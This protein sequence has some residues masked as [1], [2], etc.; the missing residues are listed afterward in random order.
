M[1]G[2]LPLSGIALAAVVGFG[3]YLVARV[4]A[5]RMRGRRAATEATEALRSGD[6]AARRR[7]ERSARK[8]ARTR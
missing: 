1:M 4:V 5:Q 7:A 2:D 6:R 3:S 8:A